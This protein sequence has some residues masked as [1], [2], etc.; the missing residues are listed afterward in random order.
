MTPEQIRKIRAALGMT[1]QQ[2]AEAI[3]GTQITVS[4]WETGVSHPTGAYRKALED[5][6]KK[7]QKIKTKKKKEGN[8]DRKL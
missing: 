7:S 2:L 6:K 3:G 1:Q 8:H 5:L 4:R